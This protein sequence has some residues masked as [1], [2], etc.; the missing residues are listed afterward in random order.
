MASVK[1]IQNHIAESKLTL[2]VVAVYGVVVW[3]L[4]GVVANHWWPQLFCFALST[5]LLIELNNSN[6]LIRVYSRTV[7]CSFIGLM[8]TA[9][10]LFG[11]LSGGVVQLCFIAAVLLLFQTYQDETSTG[12]CFYAFAA[13]GVG[14]LFFVQIFYYVPVLWLLMLTNLLC[15]KW[16][17]FL[18]S[19]LGLLAPYWFV[20]AYLVY[21]GDPMSLVGHFA[22]LGHWSAPFDLTVLSDSQVLVLALCLLLALTGIVHFWRNSYHDKIRIRLLYGCF[23]VL[24]LFTAALLLLQP[25]HYSVLIRLLIVVISPLIGHFLALTY[26]R[27]S[28]I[29][30]FAITLAT[31]ALTVYNLWMPL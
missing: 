3:L 19:V 13:I 17:T 31:L 2:P 27:I 20:T 18:A 14:S 4:A 12:R 8:C 1:H 5:Y 7:S 11:S 9:P 29:A 15:M 10:F 23:T 30:F 21:F 28:N 24:V 16:R 26:T 25:Q 6:A 22:A